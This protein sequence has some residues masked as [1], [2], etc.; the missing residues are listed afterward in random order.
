[1]YRLGLLRFI[2]PE[3]QKCAGIYGENFS[4]DKDLLDHTLD[5]AASQPPD[6]NLRLSVLLYNIKSI[7]RFDEKKEIMVKILQRIKFKNAVIKKVT[8][9]TKENWQ[10][11]N[12]SK[13]I[14]IRQLT[15]RVGME[16]LEDAWELKKALVKESRSSERFKSVEIERGENNIREILQ[17]RPPVSLKDLAVNGKDLIELGY[18]DGKEIGQILKELLNL[19]LEKPALNQEKILLTWVKEKNFL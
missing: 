2:I 3:L 14:N 5:M 18:N 15:S 11:L 9:L 4:D 17:E 1:M 8:I 10:V 19:V 13:K 16:N 6:L 7:S 12:F